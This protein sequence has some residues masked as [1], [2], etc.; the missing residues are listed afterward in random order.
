MSYWK[1]LQRC[2][3]QAALERQD[4]SCTYLAHH[5]LE[6]VMVIITI[7]V[8]VIA[9]VVVVVVIVKVIVDVIVI[10]SVIK[11]NPLLVPMDLTDHTIL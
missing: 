7:I 5:E 2:T 8:A 9:V 6:S 11:L 10:I 4:L 1:A 3:R